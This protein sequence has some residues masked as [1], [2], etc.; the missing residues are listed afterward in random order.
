[1]TKKSNPTKLI[2]AAAVLLVMI[3]CC[4]CLV[5]AWFQGTAMREGISAAGDA[6]E[7]QAVSGSASYRAGGPQHFAFFEPD[8][9]GW[10]WTQYLGDAVPYAETTEEV[11]VVLCVQEIE[12]V[13][14]ETCRYEGGHSVTRTQYR[15]HVRVAA[16]ES[17]TA[18]MDTHMA[19]TA[20]APC[21]ASFSTGGGG[22][23]IRVGPIP[24]GSVGGADETED[25]LEGSRPTLDDVGRWAS[26]MLQ[27]G[28]AEAPAPSASSVVLASC[29]GQAQTSACQTFSMSGRYIR[30]LGAEMAAEVCRGGGGTWS[31]EGHCPS[32][33]R[34][35]R[36]GSPDGVVTH[37]YGSGPRPFTAETAE[38][39]CVTA[40]DGGN[41]F[42][43]ESG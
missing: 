21:P 28:A 4:G 14:L 40:G 34:V 39:A 13:Q 16:A 9:E 19:G 22:V 30:N 41:R 43:P 18:L 24:V 33:A 1:M 32:E 37:Y 17:G 11:S 25:E 6:C 7:G 23:G 31:S 20:P 12:P 5:F 15:R 27:E 2:V 38:R 29:D 35:G 3:S 42:F 8:R 36:C 26:T 10:S